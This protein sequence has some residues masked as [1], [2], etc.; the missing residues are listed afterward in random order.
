MNVFTVSLR[1]PVPNLR[2]T[3]ALFL[4]PGCPF[5]VTVRL[6]QSC[7]SDRNFCRSSHSGAQSSLR[8]LSFNTNAVPM[9]N[10]SCYLIYFNATELSVSAS[11]QQQSDVFVE[12]LSDGKIT[13]IKNCKDRPHICGKEAACRSF[14][15]NSSKCVCPHDLS[16]PTRD[17]RCPNRLT[18]KLRDRN[19]NSWK[20]FKNQK[21]NCKLNYYII[22]F[23][24]DKETLTLI[25]CNK[26][27]S[28][29]SPDTS[30]NTQHY[31]PIFERQ[32]QY[33]QYERVSECWAGIFAGKYK[34]MLRAS[35]TAL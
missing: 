2:I 20:E 13:E 1:S 31:T 12:P 32:Q 28:F 24:C 14:E 34:K 3:P 7:E 26:L 19:C 5:R 23:I 18:G 10:I 11:N 27:F 4:F 16:S 15:D 8:W 17:L 6:Q 30:T 21:P 29:S 9:K 22:T 25:N 33:K 35:F